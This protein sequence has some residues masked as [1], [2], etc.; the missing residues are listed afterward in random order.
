MACL[1][2]FDPLLGGLPVSKNSSNSL[3]EDGKDEKMRRQ[4]ETCSQH[5]SHTEAVEPAFPFSQRW[6]WVE[7]QGIASHRTFIAAGERYEMVS[8]D[9]K[10]CDI[11]PR[12]YTMFNE[13]YVPQNRRNFPVSMDL[14]VKLTALLGQL[15][16]PV[17]ITV[18]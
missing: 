12:R 2:S 4:Q 18:C 9:C 14:C 10:L 11:Y 16:K 8:L 17:L 1:Q 7:H 13:F 3:K 15:I 6:L 5:D